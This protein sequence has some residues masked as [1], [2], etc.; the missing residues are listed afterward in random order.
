M[1]NKKICN[2][3][4]MCSPLDIGF[5]LFIM[6]IALLFI[7][8][9]I[10]AIIGIIVNSNYVTVNATII[11][12]KNLS[13]EIPNEIYTKYLVYFYYEDQIRNA[14]ILC[15]TEYC[16]NKYDKYKIN[17]NIILY[18]HYGEFKFEVN[19]IYIINCIVII[20]LSIIIFNVI[21]CFAILYVNPPFLDLD[22]LIKIKK[23]KF[24]KIYQDTSL[25]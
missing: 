16:I 6:L 19:V 7:L 10:L 4:K 25:E 23:N 17:D 8:I 9:N 22:N 5:F 12:I 18:L 21:S 11:N 20:P 2:S 13:L 14:T 3:C 15:R 1:N 24:K